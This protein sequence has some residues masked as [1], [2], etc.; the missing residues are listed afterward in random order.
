[1][2][3]GLQEQVPLSQ[4]KPGFLLQGTNVE[5]KPL[6]GYRRVKG[7]A[8]WDS[9]VV[10]GEGDILGVWLY[11]G[12]VY[13]VRNAVGGATAEMHSSVG[14]GWTLVKSGLTPSGSYEFIN[15]NFAGTNKMYGVSGVHKAFE[16]DGTTWTDITSGMTTDTPKHVLAFKQHLFLSFDASTQFSSIGDPLTWSPISG[17]GELLMPSPVTGLVSMQGGVMG[18]L[19]RNATSILQGSSSANFTSTKLTEHG[20]KVGA[21]EGTLQQLGSRVWFLDDAGVTSIEAATKFGAFADAVISNGVRSRLSTYKNQVNCSCVVKDKSQ[22]R[23]FFNDGRGMIFSFNKDAL[24]G[25]TMF[26][27]PIVITKVVSSE[28]ASGD[29]QILAGATDGYI[30]WLEQGNNFDGAGIYS[31]LQTHFYGYN[32]PRMN[33]RFRRMSATLGGGNTTFYVKPETALAGDSTLSEAYKTFSS[34]GSG[35]VLGLDTLGAFKL[36]AAVLSEAT[37]DIPCHGAYLSLKI[38]TD[39]SSGDP[40]ELDDIIITYEP[41][42]TRRG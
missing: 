21:I 20:T 39:V 23:L 12:K 36:S 27:Y 4:N 40:W 22:Y 1:M 33:K 42:R 7:L 8:K 28:D 13:A 26:E 2:N 30:Y 14:S 41:R 19:C 15:A 31:Y 24:V 9:N 38:Y 16:Y 35:S 18:I 10:P 3:G 11:N 25:I 29:E 32:A 34:I 37:A 5:C 17:A 6:G